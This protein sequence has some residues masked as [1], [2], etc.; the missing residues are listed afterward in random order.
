MRDQTTNYANGH[1]YYR[2]IR[3]LLLPFP[4]PS[5]NCTGQVRPGS[6]S[7]RIERSLGALN[8][9][10]ARGEHRL[11]QPAILTQASNQPALV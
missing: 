7:N 4:R 8:G 3:G 11:P 6:E 9:F 1:E 2:V 5:L 10:A